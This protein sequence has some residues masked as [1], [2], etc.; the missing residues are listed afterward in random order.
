[1]RYAFQCGGRSRAAVVCVLVELLMGCGYSPRASVRGFVTVDG[2]AVEAGWIVFRNDTII[3]RGEIKGGGAFALEHHGGADVPRG[4]YCVMLFPPD[5]EV[6]VDAKT[7]GVR[8]LSL[9]N[10]LIYPLR[11]RSMETSDMKQQVDVGAQIIH[12]S[13]TSS[14]SESK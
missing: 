13:F 8:S 1:M 9:S 7:G 10:E 14:V 4:V 5:R 6:L 11:Y 3:L 2:K 12:L